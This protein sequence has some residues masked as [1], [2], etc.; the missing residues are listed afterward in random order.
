VSEYAVLALNVN[1]NMTGGVNWR[2]FILLHDYGTRDMDLF[3]DIRDLGIGTNSATALLTTSGDRA[4]DHAIRIR[5][6]DGTIAWIMV[7]QTA[8]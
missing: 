3:L 1:D 6:S 4:Q 8:P 2:T 5:L 7:T